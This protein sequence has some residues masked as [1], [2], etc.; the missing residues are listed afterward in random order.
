MREWG[1]KAA[2]A[3]ALLVCMAVLL[4]QNETAS[5]AVRQGL[6]LCARS[7]IPSLFPFFVVVSFA[8]GCGFFT[9]LRRLGLPV[10]AAVFLMGIVGGY[11]VGARTVGELY[12]GG[13]LARERAETLLTFCNNAGPSFIFAIAGVGVFGSQKTGLALYVIH[14]LS[15]LAAGGLLGG[16]RSVRSASKPNRFDMKHGSND[17]KTARCDMKSAGNCTKTV[18][19]GAKLPALFVSC[20]GSAAAAMVNIC[21]F[22]IFFLVLLRLAESFLGPLPPLAAGLVELTNGI[23]PL[24]LGLL[25][26]TGGVTSLEASPA[27]FCMAAALLGWGGVSVHCQTA[28]V[29]EDTGISLRRYLLAKALQAVVSALFALGVCRFF[30]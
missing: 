8:V 10:G 26:L 15:A 3:A 18:G 4:W 20:V 23:P 28:A 22:V 14:I 2:L 12:R 25:E 11:P 6:A 7:V 27:G 30:F 19:N 24:A 16:L 17:M 5:A 1:R 9:V 21:A 29:L 13:G